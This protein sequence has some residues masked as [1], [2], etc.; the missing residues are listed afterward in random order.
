MYLYRM[1][2]DKR[3]YQQPSML[4][5]AENAWAEDLNHSSYTLLPRYFLPFS[6][7]IQNLQLFSCPIDLLT[8]VQYTQLPQA[9]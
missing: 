6:K 4:Q 8:F 5:S 2:R 1:Q 7:T 3:S 9:S